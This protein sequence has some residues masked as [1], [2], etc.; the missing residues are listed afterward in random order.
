[1]DLNE[2]TEVDRE[3]ATGCENIAMNS[4][5]FVL[6]AKYETGVPSVKEDAIFSPQ[7]FGLPDPKFGEEICVFLRLREEAILTEHDV[8]K[9]CE[10][11]MS[12]SWHLFIPGKNLKSR[13]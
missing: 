5:L 12:L 8:R 7:A 6:D 10:D 11:N 4:P 1:V 3:C 13:T 9:Y 2:A